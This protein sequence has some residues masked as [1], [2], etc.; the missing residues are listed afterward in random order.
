MEQIKQTLENILLDI[1]D[2]GILNDGNINLL[3]TAIRD[4]KIVV[5]ELKK[6]D[7][8]KFGE[9]PDHINEFQEAANEA[10]T[11]K[12]NVDLYHAYRTEVVRKIEDAIN[13]LS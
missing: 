10:R 12:T 4:Y 7:K 11:S 6:T 3:N 9:L 13:L 1:E 5:I 2:T 8:S